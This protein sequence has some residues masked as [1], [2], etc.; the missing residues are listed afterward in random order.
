MK[1]KEVDL[2]IFD[3]DGTLTDSIP[4]AINAVQDM[5]KE[6]GL[7]HKT[8]K[9]I[10][11][12]VG[13]GEAPLIAGSIGTKEP[14]ILDKAM[15]SYIK[16]YKQKRIYKILPYPHVKE[17]LEGHKNKTLAIISNKKDEFI[18]I[19][20][21]NTNLLQYFKDIYGGDTSPCLKPDPCVIETIMDKYHAKQN[22]TLFVGDMTIDIET[23]KNAGVLTCAVTYGFDPK[24]KLELLKPDFMVDDILTLR[25]FIC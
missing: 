20:L 3:F 24:S 9:E 7:P 23:G 16:H 17:F 11:K 6:L 22:K 5:L 15:N 25:K 4:E 18:R 2:I 10:G 13:F 1:K 21:K 14:K 12:H 8:S 19:I